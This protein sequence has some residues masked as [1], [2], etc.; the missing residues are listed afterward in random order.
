M[1][2]VNTIRR[3]HMAHHNPAIMMERNM[4]LTFPLDW[5]FGTSDLDRGLLGHCSTV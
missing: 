2:F 5:L 3:H 1:P 4:N